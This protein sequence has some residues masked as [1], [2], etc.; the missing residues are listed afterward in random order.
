[1][2]L[3][4]LLKMLVMT[5]LVATG[6]NLYKVQA[7]SV[8]TG[9]AQTQKV[10]DEHAGHTHAAT[11]DHSG[12]DHAHA[13]TE[14]GHEKDHGGHHGP[15]KDLSPFWCIPFALMLLS[16]A[17]LPLF[18][19][20]WWEE[21]SNKMKVA[22]PLGLIVGVYLV[23]AYGSQGMALIQHSVIEYIQFIC[24]LGSLYIISGGIVVKGS[25]VGT[26][27]FNATVLALGAAIA[28]IVGTT[29]ASM[30]L[31]RPII[32]ANVA[33]KHVVHIFIFFIFMVSNCGGLLTP[34]GDPPLFLGFLKG[35]PF[36]WTLNL[37]KPWLFVN[38]ILLII[39]FV[40]DSI[41]Y[42]KEEFIEEIKVVEKEPFKLEGTLNFVWLA[43]VVFSVAFLTPDFLAKLGVHPMGREV[44]MIVLIGLSLQM[45]SKELREYNQFNY[46]PIIEVA[47]L[48]VGIFVTMIPA[49]NTLQLMGPAL[50]VTQP[51]QFFWFTGILSSFLDNAP[52]Y[53]VFYELAG[54]LGLSTELYGPVIANNVPHTILAA[55]SMGAVFM[56]ANSYIGNGPNFM[57]KAIAEQ[58]G[59][60][61]PSF[62]GYMAYSVGILIPV[63]LL[64]HYIFITLKML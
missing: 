5:F 50:G 37:W 26:P 19:E 53:V 24:L 39:F 58:S 23:G 22:V 2:K 63:F 62:F 34:L 10:H 25:M 13:H 31:I 20:H 45:T 57:V 44:V 21:N 48:F 32:R 41:V 27:K 51:A 52:T 29:G 38:G 14:A 40:W 1:M 33:R 9:V 36:E 28:S 42:K 8:A 43:G 15:I 47:V 3:G 18:A 61:M 4:N 16:I 35:V 17:I 6:P 55:I 54:T 12:H 59:I 56:G 64:V 46:H 49:I 7:A 11:E 30:L 60:K